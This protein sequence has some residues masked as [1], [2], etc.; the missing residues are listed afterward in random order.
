M[1]R[2]LPVL[3]LLLISGAAAATERVALVIG[4]AG[5]QVGRLL[6]PANDAND[7]AAALTDMGFDV[8]AGNDL[9]RSGLLR[10]LAEFRGKLQPGGIA[11]VFYAGHAVEVSGEN[12][13]LPVDNAQIKSQADVPIHA[14]SAQ[15]LLAK[16]EEG[17]ARLNV[18]ILDACR[19]DPLPRTA[20]SSRQGLAAIQTRASTLVAYSTAPG[21]TAED[22]S[23][24]NSVYT[25][26]LKDALRTPGISVTDL[27]NKVGAQ[28][29]DSTGG[30]QT[31]WNS[32]TPVWPPVM[33]VGANNVAETKLTFGANEGDLRVKVIPAQARIF[34]DGKYLGTG[35]R[36]IRL[37]A[38]SRPVVRVE[39]DGFRPLEQVV[40]IQQGR[41]TDF[42]LDVPARRRSAELIAAT[43]S[44]ARMAEEFRLQKDGTVLDLSTG[45]EWRQADNGGTTTFKGARRHCKRLGGQWR[46][47]LV[48]ELQSL[49]LYDATA[50]TPCGDNDGRVFHCRVSRHFKLTGPWFWTDDAYDPGKPWY[51]NYNYMNLV[52]GRAYSESTHPLVTRDGRSLCVR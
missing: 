34:V 16:V 32:G 45:L 6:N 5:Y 22:G 23:G 28:V 36:S 30:A 20:R 33:L 31:P 41:V 24:R 1:L 40:V 51:N 42:E 10:K 14:I 3:F 18:L 44:D 50:G 8:V 46:L 12:W 47:P 17:G 49:V 4:N 13:L 29:R 21:M 19:N 43:P 11:I 15:H 37:P 52:E 48:R 7:I 39:I 25:N 26:L 35:T 38:G 27:F 2:T 9:D